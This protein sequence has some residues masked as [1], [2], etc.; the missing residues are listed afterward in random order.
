MTEIFTLSQFLLVTLALGGVLAL[1]TTSTAKFFLSVSAMLAA[2]VFF[3]A[4]VSWSQGAN[5]LWIASLFLL[6]YS[7]VPARIRGI[8]AASL[9]MAV[10]CWCLPI[11]VDSLSISSISLIGGDGFVSSTFVSLTYVVLLGAPIFLYGRR[12]F[13]V[14][15]LPAVCIG[16][17]YCSAALP[18]T[19]DP[20]CFLGDWFCFSGEYI[21]VLPTDLAILF[22]SGLCAVYLVFAQCGAPPNGRVASEIST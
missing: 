18:Q 21:G 12:D 5:W 15:T 3:R 6:L 10:I 11:T 20:V 4:D 17:L 8:N 7:L 13:S 2:G 19:A 1:F 14:H 16:Q 9:A 22:V